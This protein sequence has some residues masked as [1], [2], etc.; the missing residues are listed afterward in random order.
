MIGW[1][2]D[3]VLHAGVHGTRY[4][5]YQVVGHF[6]GERFT[7]TE[8]ATVLDDAPQRPPPAPDPFERRRGT[9]CPPPAGGWRPVDPAT[10]THEALQRLIEVAE[11]DPGHSALWVD[12]NVPPGEVDQRDNNPARIIVN[13]A[14]TGDT[15]ALERRLRAVWGG[16]LCVSR[17]ARSVADLARIQQ[18]IDVPRVLTARPNAR[19]GRLHLT[20]IRATT[21]L[22]ADLDARYG[23]GSV[24]LIG[25]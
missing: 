25:A 14:T 17:G 6:D 11:A 3:A 20:V 15:A 4:G 13:V 7:L 12:Q 8:P 22:Q 18:D 2:W 24:N 23:P 9:P 21:Q 1:S 10:A 5:L 19:A 16:A